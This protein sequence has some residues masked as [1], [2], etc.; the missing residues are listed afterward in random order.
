M[1]LSKIS[2]KCMSCPFVDKCQNKRM[3]ALAYMTESQVSENVASPN[4]QNLAAPLLRETMTIM[5]NDT[6]T[7]VYRDEIEKQIYSQ[8][9]SGLGLKFGS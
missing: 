7:Q 9:Y 5:V 6:P 3:E 1:G 4:Y 2:E 8:L